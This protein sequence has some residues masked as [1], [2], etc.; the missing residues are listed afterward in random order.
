MIRDHAQR[1]VVAVRGSVALAGEPLGGGDDRAQD[2]GLVVPALVLQDRTDALEAHARVDVLGGELG[3]LALRVAVVL[4]EDEVPELD[5]A[6]AT[7]VH[8]AAM[9]RVV[10]PITRVGTPVDV[11]LRARPAR[12]GLGHL[13]EVLGIEAEH[14]RGGQIRHLG[15]QPRGLVVARV[16]GREEA[17]LRE[18]PDGRQ[19]LPRPRDRLPLVV[20]AE[21][22]VAKHLEE[23]VMVGVA[24]HLLEVVVLATDAE[25]LLAV[26]GPHVRTAL[27]AEEHLFELHHAG[28]GEEQARVVLWD[29]RR[30]RHDGV[31]ALLKEIQER[32]ADLI[33]GHFR[34]CTGSG[35]RQQPRP[36][37]RTVPRRSI[38]HGGPTD[39]GPL[40][41]AGCRRR[42]LP[43]DIRRRREPVRVD[44]RALPARE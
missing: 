4:D 22:P 11:D 33:S 28:V 36:G 27:V 9:R 38:L 32:L 39:P 21:G 40:P 5:V 30:A 23:G 42:P 43:G 8:P 16:H 35:W 7:R 15:P 41:P 20:V 13:P 29:Q 6:G 26:D 34:S 24:S 17:V 10:A 1:D 12:A 18:L 44:R 2:V 37:G 25:A 3:E 14:P 31:P 19:Q